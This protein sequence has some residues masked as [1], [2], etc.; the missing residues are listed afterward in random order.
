MSADPPRT[1]DYHEDDVRRAGAPRLEVVRG[2]V[3]RGPIDLAP[4]TF[5]VGRDEEADLRFDSVGVSRKHARLRIDE[6]GMVELFDL[7]SRNGSFV[8]GQRVDR[9]AL[10]VGD[11]LRFGEVVLRLTVV[12]HAQGG[13]EPAGPMRAKVRPPGLS[14]RE[15]EVASLAAEGLT[16]AEIGRRL[17]ISGATVGRHLSNIYERLNIHSR[18]ALVR[19]LTGI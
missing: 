1:T 3:P 12:G 4:G 18:V 16:N 15:F 17:D 7:Q 14:D 10:R 8:N 6:Q 19:M 9:L 11:E 2:T 13:E 5:L